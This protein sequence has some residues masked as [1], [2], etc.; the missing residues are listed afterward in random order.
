MFSNLA[1]KSI[2]KKEVTSFQRHDFLA[3]LL[4]TMVTSVSNAAAVKK[5]KGTPH[6][7]VTPST[8]VSGDGN[9]NRRKRRRLTSPMLPHAISN[10]QVPSPVEATSDGAC[11]VAETEEELETEVECENKED[12]DKTDKSVIPILDTNLLISESNLYKFVSSNFVCKL[13][14]GPV[15]EKN[16]HSDKI[17]LACN[18]FFSCKNKECTG[19]GKVL[20][21]P[22]STNTS[23][24]F[25]R[26]HPEL[27]S[28][29]GDY[30]INRQVVLACQQSGGGGRVA[31]TFGGLLSISRRSIWTDSFTQVEEIIGMAQIRLGKRIIAENLEEEIS[32]SPMD[33]ALNRAKVVTGMDGGWDQ[34]ASG[35]SFNSP[36]G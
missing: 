3:R 35:K 29:L 2:H 9:G 16:L 7:L 1:K 6:F 31:S 34:R 8:E 27:P 18:L 11:T 14:L 25:R 15:L 4:V 22:S 24:N 30:D 28:G 26:Y 21:K 12:E 5:L 19:V 36:S 17:G 13:C 10:L 20:S 33:L 23:G 32:L